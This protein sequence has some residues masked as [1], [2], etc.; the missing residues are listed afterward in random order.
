VSPI[1]LAAMDARYRELKMETWILKTLE[2]R[3]FRRYRIS[4]TLFV[5]DYFI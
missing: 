1:E 2:T 3:E 4:I 5:D